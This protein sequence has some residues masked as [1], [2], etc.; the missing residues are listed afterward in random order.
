MWYYIIG[1]LFIAAFCFGV[2]GTLCNVK[3][4]KTCV[5]DSTAI[6]IMAILWPLIIPCIIGYG[7]FK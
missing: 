4:S 5:K 3:D 6:L 7:L 1:Y 2:F